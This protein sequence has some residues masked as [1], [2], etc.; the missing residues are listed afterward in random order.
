MEDDF[1][2]REG[3]PSKSSLKRDAHALQQLGTSLVKLDE[4]VWHSL[5][6]PPELVDALREA[7]H[8]RS[9]GAHK[10]QL[11]Y[12]GKLMRE[13]DPEPIRD[14][15]ERQ[16]QQSRLRIREQQRLEEW[17]ERLIA[18]GDPAVEEFLQSHADADRQHLRQLVRQARKEKAQDKA[19]RSSRAL[20]RYLRD[21][22]S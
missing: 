16:R 2:P 20:F 7:R 8:I 19:P 21:L 14:Y 17:R 12:I 11:Q 4:S 1:D 5:Q 13:V 15:F 18:E 3:P 10:R 6:L 9:R 22:Q